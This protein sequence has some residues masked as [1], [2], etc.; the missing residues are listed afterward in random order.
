MYS[1]NKLPPFYIGSTS[2]Q[3]LDSGYIGSVGSKKYKKIWLSEKRNNPE[4]FVVKIISKHNTRTEALER[5]RDLQVK[6]NVLRNPL[7]VNQSI[8]APRGYAGMDVKK[9]LNPNYGNKWSRE[10]KLAHSEKIKAQWAAGER[11]LSA[12]MI[13]DKRGN[14]NPNYGNRWNDEQRARMSGAN[15]P[16]YGKGMKGNDNPMYGKHG[17]LHHRA[18]VYVVTNMQTSVSYYVYDRFQFSKDFGVNFVSMFNAK[19]A[20]TPVTTKTKWRITNELPRDPSKT[21][22]YELN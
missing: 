13:G 18:K 1:G 16:M 10:K 17:Q 21:I 19:R 5:E 7:Y 4:L 9:E 3:R 11:T 22:P 6:L 8:A 2:C 15:N 12:A 20:N 14:L